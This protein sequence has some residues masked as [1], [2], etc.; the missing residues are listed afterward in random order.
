MRPLTQFTDSYLETLFWSECQEN[1]DPMD[2]DFGPE[3]LAP[4]ALEEI[5]KD[6]TAFFWDN[7]ELLD[8]TPESYTYEQAGHDFA[9]TRNGHGAGFWDRGLEKLGDD[10]TAACDGYGS[11]NLYIGDDGL[12]YV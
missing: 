3:D 8:Q 5:K 7:R 9:L 2:D 6:C 12:V 10:L 11:Q 4:E 1:G